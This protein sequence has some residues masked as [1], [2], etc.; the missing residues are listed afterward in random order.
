MAPIIKWTDQFKLG[1]EEMDDQHFELITRINRLIIAHDNDENR[2]SIESLLTF[3]KSY[4]VEHFGAE[5]HLQRQYHYAGYDEHRKEHFEFVK[6]VAEF[7]HAFKKTADCSVN[8]D[9]KDLLYEIN[10]KLVDWLSNHIDQSDRL[11]AEHI[12]KVLTPISKHG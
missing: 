2:D 12:K 8:G 11:V 9:C 7:E 10:N 5:E 1:I 6:L 3:L 4:V